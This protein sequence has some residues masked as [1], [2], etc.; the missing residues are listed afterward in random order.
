MGQGRLSVIGV[1]SYP[2]SPGYHQGIGSGGH[3]L[4]NLFRFM[5]DRRLAPGEDVELALQEIKEAVGDM[6]P[7]KVTFER[8]ALHYPWKHAEND[9]IIRSVAEAYLEALDE[10]PQFRYVNFT[11]D[12]GWMNMS[13]IPTVMFGAFDLRFSHGDVEFTNLN[14]TCQIAKVYTDWAISNAR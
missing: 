10:A 4:Q 9:P 14:E 6:S 2:F 5:L 7:W 1:A 8:G 11:I 3:T 13:G 12:A